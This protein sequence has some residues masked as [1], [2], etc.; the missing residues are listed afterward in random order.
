MNN[1][2]YRLLAAVCIAFCLVDVGCVMVGKP[3][4]LPPE[5]SVLV[6]ATGQASPYP[7]VNL[8]MIASTPVHPWKDPDDTKFNIFHV[9]ELQILRHPGDPMRQASFI[10]GGAVYPFLTWQER[11]G[12]ILLAPG[13]NP[14][15]TG[16]GSFWEEYQDIA[17]KEKQGKNR[18]AS[19][20]AG[21][22]VCDASVSSTENGRKT[23][24][25]PL[26]GKD[27]VI[28]VD[29]SMLVFLLGLDGVW[30]DL[31]RAH[32]D[33]KDKEAVILTCRTIDQMAKAHHE[34]WPDHKWDS[35]RQHVIDWCHSIAE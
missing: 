6:D 35:K 3:E 27:H 26:N 31:R 19:Y 8:V 11:R 25:V 4:T 20:H 10:P 24:F 21:A 18:D 1:S 15:G 2:I 12:N 16:E 23:S 5:R 17:S 14:E 32:N 34:K 7:C 22:S 9:Q 30:A 28:R 33:P 13:F 29:H